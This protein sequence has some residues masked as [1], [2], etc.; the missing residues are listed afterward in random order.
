MGSRY[1]MLA[2]VAVLLAVPFIASEYYL[3]I[4]NLIFIAIVGAI[5]LN[6]LVG[7]T[8]QVSIGHGAFRR[9]A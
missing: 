7:N 9:E 1:S 6:I 8:G 2:L 3:S 5:G 4:L